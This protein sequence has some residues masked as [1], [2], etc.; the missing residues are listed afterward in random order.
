MKVWDI[1]YFNQTTVRKRTMHQLS[2][3]KRGSATLIWVW[4][5]RDFVRCASTQDQINCMKQIITHSSVRQHAA[6]GLSHIWRD[7]CGEQ[8]FTGSVKE[9]IEYDG[10]NHQLQRWCQ[11]L[12]S[13]NFVV[14]HRCARMM[15]NGD[16]LTRRYGK[17]I[18]LYCVQAHLIRC[19][20]KLSRPLAYDVDYFQTTSKPHRIL[21]S[22]SS[23]VLLITIPPTEPITSPCKISALFYFAIRISKV[24]SASTHS[25]L[26]HSKDNSHSN[27]TG[28]HSPALISLDTII[29]TLGG[30]ISAWIGRQ[31]DHHVFE[32]T[33]L[34][35]DIAQAASVHSTVHLLSIHKLLVYFQ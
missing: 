26:P 21:P 19:K 18:A 15:R 9:I 33:M 11:E 34:F 2:C 3:P 4:K 16:A 29:S 10:C 32:S 14:I 7:T 23:S 24:P 20:D 31:L 35:H 25:P 12:M 27:F 1:S 13:Y 17:T 6:A 30:N 22:S 8:C 28:H 5:D